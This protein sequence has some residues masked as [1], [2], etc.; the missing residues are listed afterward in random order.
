MFTSGSPNSG[1]LQIGIAL[2]LEDRFSNQARE[3]S[4]EI[5]RLHQE[6]KNVTNANLNAAMKVATVGAAVGG[7]LL[8]GIRDAVLTGAEFIDTLTFV[9][10]ITSATGGDLDR[11]GSKAKKLGRDTMFTANEIGSAM[12]FMALAGQTVEEIYNNITATANLANATMTEIGGKGGAADILTNIMRMY[13]ITSSEMNSTRVADV[14][15]KAVTRSNTNLYDLGEAIKYAGSTAVNLGASVEQTAAFVGVLGDAGI[16]GSMAGTALG[17]AYRYLARSVGDPNFKGGKALKKLGLGKQDFVD[18]QGNLIDLG[19]ALQKIAKASAG[20][21]MIDRYNLLVSILGVRG[22]RAGSININAFERY[23]ELLRQIN[24]ESDGIALEVQEKRLASLAGAVNIVKSTWENLRISFT[25]SLENTLQPF[26]RTIG[27]VFETLQ[28]LFESPVGPYVA[29]LLTIGTAYTTLRLGAIALKSSWRL[30]F[31]DSTVSAAN[32]MSVLNAGWTGNNIKAAEYLALQ[33]AINAQHAAGIA[34][35]GRQ[36]FN[37]TLWAA[38]AMANQGRYY[39]GYMAKQNKKGQWMYYQK[40]ASGGVK[41]VKG[42]DILN[43]PNMSQSGSQIVSQV[44]SPK[45]SRV[46]QATNIGLAGATGAAVAKSASARS[47]GAAAATGAVAGTAAR[48]GIGVALRSIVSFL[49]G[50]WGFA[51]ITIASFIPNIY[52]AIKNNTDASKE[53]SERLRALTP[54]EKRQESIRAADLSVEERS[55]LT[56]HLLRTLSEQL[57]RIANN[58][59]DKGTTQIILNVD[60]QTLI[61]DTIN[62]NQTQ[63]VINLGL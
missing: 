42:S 4:S 30:L 1:Q 53:N 50:P 5:R 63:Q 43:S 17:N 19:V 54:S 52:A 39:G 32:M 25:G 36:S 10:A 60:G 3:A 16:Q 12:Q 45:A 31:N 51:L 9:G 61:Q 15:T 47:V 33:K 18:A 8:A 58:T 57:N 20:M 14:L 26:L 2:V 40:D 48:L 6:A 46:Q 55:V 29:S 41:R 28:R 34:G 22:E 44:S 24:N 27:V 37:S 7:T 56:G 13:K 38:Q 21:D 23:T 35:N 62:N 11:L 49:G 59:Q